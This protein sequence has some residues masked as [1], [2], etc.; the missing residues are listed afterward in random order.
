M[1]ETQR[2]IKAYKAA[3]PGLR[4]RV[5]AVALLLAMSVA[6]MTSATFAWLTLSQAPEVSG[7][8]TTVA[9]N[10]NLEIALAKADGTSPDE[11]KIGDSSAR[12]GQTVSNANLTWGNLVNLADPAYGLDHLIL[13]PAMLS[14]SG[15]LLSNPLVSVIYAND[16]RTQSAYNED[17]GFTNW[18]DARKFFEYPTTPQ[19]GVRAISSIEY[20]IQDASVLEYKALRSEAATKIQDAKDAYRA[21]VGP[22]WPAGNKPANHNANIKAIAAML[23]DFLYK[24]IMDSLDSMNCTGYILDLYPMMVDLQTAYGDVEN[25]LEAM[26]NVQVFNLM[27]AANYKDYLFDRTDP[28]ARKL[29]KVENNTIVI[30]TAALTL[31][32]GKVVKLDSLSAYV[33]SLNKLNKVVADLKLYY[34]KAYANSST[35][36]LWTDQIGERTLEA[37]INDIVHIAGCTVKDGPNGTEL[38]A[39]GLAGDLSTAMGIMGSNQVYGKINRGIIVDFE[40]LVGEGMDLHYVEVDA[41]IKK[42]VVYSI[43]T[44]AKFPGK[45]D[46]DF[47]K[48][49]SSELSN[50]S[51]EGSAEDTYGLAVDLWART[52]MENTYL[53]LEGHTVTANKEE[54]ATLSIPGGD[55]VQLYTATI[56]HP[57]NETQAGGSGDSGSLGG[58]LDDL[59]G[60]TETVDVYK[61]KQKKIINNEDGTT[62]ETEVEVWYFADTHAPVYSTTTDDEGNE[63]QKPNRGE[64]I[65][66]S[67]SPKMNTITTVIG[68]AGENRVWTDWEK[69]G[70][71]LNS[72]TQGNGSCYVFYADNPTDQ[73][74]TLKLLSNLRVVFLDETGAVI[75]KARLDTVNHYSTPGKVTIPLVLMTDT[76]VTKPTYAGDNLAI[77]PLVRNQST[78][79]TMLVYLDGTDLTNDQ[80]LAANDIQGKLNVQFGTTAEL[81]TKGDTELKLDT[82]EVSA[83]V[84]NTDF[85]YDTATGPMISHIKINVDGVNPATVTASFV[86]Q[87]SATQGSREQTITFDPPTSGNTWTKSYEFLTPGTYVLR[88][89]QLDGQEYDLKEPYPTVTVKGFGIKSVSCG[90]AVAGKVTS[91]LSDQNSY[92]TPVS[93][94]F[95]TD[96]PRKVPAS[97]QVQFVND[98]GGD[99]V[100]VL[101]TQNST[102]FAGIATFNNSG[103]YTLKY[104]I[105][106]G[107]YVELEEEKPANE[108]NLYTL[109]L[110]LGV[111]VRVM[112]NQTNRSYEFKGDSIPVAMTIEIRDKGNNVLQGLQNVQLHY[113]KDGTE[114]GAP[115]VNLTWDAES[116][117]YTGGTM[118]L[119]SPGTYYFDYVKVGNDFIHKSIGELPVYSVVS[120]NPPVYKGNLTVP[121]QFMKNAT[122]D[123]EIGHAESAIVTA[124]LYNSSTGKTVTV[125]NEEGKAAV[126]E[127]KWERTEQGVE[128]YKFTIHIPSDP[129]YGQDGV[130]TLKELKLAEVCDN[131]KVYHGSDDPWIWS[132]GSGA[133]A[134][135]EDEPV[136]EMIQDVVTTEV[137]S[138]KNPI[139]IST[140]QP[141]GQPALRL[142]YGDNTD[143]KTYVFMESAVNNAP[144]TISITDKLGNALKVPVGDVTVEYTHTNTSERYGGYTNAGLDGQGTDEEKVYTLTPAGDGKTYTVPAGTIQMAYAGEYHC[145]EINFTINNVNYRYG[146]ATGDNHLGAVP[147][148]MPKFTLTTAVPTVK[149]TAISPTST[150]S[151]DDTSGIQISDTSKSEKKSS[152]WLPDYRYYWITNAAHKSGYTPGKTDTTATVYFQCDHTNDVEYGHTQW[153]NYQNWAD[154]SKTEDFHQYTQPTVTITIAGM[155]NATNASLSFDGTGYI[156]AGA[157]GSETTKTNYSWT[158]TGDAAQTRYIGIWVDA[159]NSKND[160][161]T[162]AG[163]MKA[164]TLVMTYNGVDYNFALP[165]NIVIKNTY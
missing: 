28:D 32:S 121:Y 143:S 40:N 25:A 46:Q 77:M 9:A 4:E 12:E 123:I 64:K 164:T 131:D 27:G 51:M 72:T 132:F 10:G 127:K 161:K 129:I 158:A 117:T 36:I 74:N 42:M 146:G 11:S 67:G 21:I 104:V 118:Q 85:D 130:W 162:V 138:I 56:T 109:N 137:Q 111:Y 89:V 90:T 49:C 38:T 84:E 145:T 2:R 93:V 34:D 76:T 122:M 54:L 114:L 82:V 6:M 86:R 98:D 60:N 5:I 70:L 87:I 75:S 30:N 45:I 62:T 124:V 73:E 140:A 31:A 79:M 160:T 16:G 53:I 120:P 23:G 94:Q 15:D 18:N 163:E 165:E 20:K 22:S 33:T 96:D 153:R 1:N 110:T 61:L 13:R 106:D 133:A 19:Y 29:T 112:D 100:T 115:N 92:S 149:I 80:V 57:E 91:V 66:I 78:R 108:K 3:L 52:N 47:T 7:A 95:A 105:M 55:T 116:E 24:N 37:I 88:S 101:M 17:F 43:T 126:I 125:M 151:I 102:S 159:G 155:G 71:E 136:I 65:T 142:N 139:V 141:Q 68:F 128:I 50:T 58:A 44:A 148:A 26:A 59:L 144:F 157:G 150:F 97:V 81:Y 48:N 134:I 35:T 107:K 154:A 152:G 119:V 39:G 147:S 113:R 135:A 83:T 8:A 41:K 103:K 63:V 156:F 14:T 99:P 69:E